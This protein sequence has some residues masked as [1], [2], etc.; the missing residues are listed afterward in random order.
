MQGCHAH[1]RMAYRLLH[2]SEQSFALR[3]K[4]WVLRRILIQDHAVGSCMLGDPDLDSHFLPIECRE[5]AELRTT[6]TM[7]PLLDK[8][9]Q[10][11]AADL[12]ASPQKRMRRHA[13][14]HR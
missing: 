5:E 8:R 9:S 3:T 4:V 1:V 11:S 14:S 7:Y 2:E 10:V 13:A 6:A 12:P